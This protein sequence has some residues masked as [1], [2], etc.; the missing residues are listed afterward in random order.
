MQWNSIWSPIMSISHVIALFACRIFRLM[1]NMCKRWWTHWGIVF[2]MSLHLTPLFASGTWLRSLSLKR[3]LPYP[4]HLR[5]KW[6]KTGTC[7]CF[8]IANWWP[9]VQMK[10]LSTSLAVSPNISELFALPLSLSPSLCRLF[11]SL[12]LSVLGIL[13]LYRGNQGNMKKEHKPL[14]CPW[15]IA[16]NWNNSVL[17]DPFCFTSMCLLVFCS[18]SLHQSAQRSNLIA[19]A[20]RRGC[21]L[22]SLNI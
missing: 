18:F 17:I 5:M 21:S 8:L 4:H 2:L 6:R 22:M 19:M 1:E 16:Q 7:S 9:L 11:F 14:G 3:K 20:P 13:C 12:S 15:E 10:S